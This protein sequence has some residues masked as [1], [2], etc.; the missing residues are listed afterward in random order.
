MSNIVNKKLS[1]RIGTVDVLKEQFSAPKEKRHTTFRTEISATDEFG[2]VLFSNEHNETVLGGAI[3][4][5]EKMWG[6]RSPLQVATINE[7]M[8]IN[9]NV[10]VDPN[11]LTQDDIVCLWGV[12][13][14]GSG[15]AFGSIRPVNFYEREVGQN[16]QRDEMIP[17]RVV[18]T[19]LSGDD[20]AKYHMMEERHSD[21][22]FAY[23]LKG[24]EQKPQ[25]KILWKDGEEGEDGSEVE[26]DVHNTSRR[27]LI[28]AFVEMHLKLT[29]KDVREW[30]DVNGNIQLSRIN[31]IALFTGKRVEIAPGK[32]DYVNVKMFSKLNLDNEPLTNTKEIN[33]T[34]RIYTN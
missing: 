11:P 28:E 22:L 18:Q 10:G 8:D 5:M 16:G 17:F 33:F 27:D 14:G 12:G 2:N 1:D 26:S 9:S 19:P 29:K 21:G 30:F 24:F 31:T 4:V 13:I 23:Y 20:A 7:I 34:Y 32:F 15:D 6:I 25:I 3:T